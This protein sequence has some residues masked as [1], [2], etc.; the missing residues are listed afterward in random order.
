VGH[1]RVKDHLKQKITQFVLKALHIAVFY[2]V[3][4]FVRFFDRIR[5]DCFEGLLK[6][7]GTTAIRIPQLGHDVKKPANVAGFS[8]DIHGWIITSVCGR[9][10]REWEIES[11]FKISDI[12]QF[13]PSRNMDRQV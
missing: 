6:I 10:K 9:R 8:W 7:P 5:D 3:R 13:S 2:G 11:N 1:L 4:D 12:A